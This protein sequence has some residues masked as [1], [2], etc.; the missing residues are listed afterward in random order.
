MQHL[1]VTGSE[2]FIGRE[3]VRAAAA[4]GARITTLDAVP[5]M[6]AGHVRADIRDR[7]LA[8]RIP[9]DVDCVVHLAAISRDGD[10]KADP[11]L[12]L[13]VNVIGTQNVIDAAV[14]RGVRQ[15]IFASSEWV[16]GEVERAGTQTERD[17]IDV[18]RV[19][20]EYALSKLVGERLVANAAARSG[21]AGTVLRFGIV[22]GPR[23]SNWSAVESLFAKTITEDTVTV[24]CGATARRFIHVSDIA[25]GILAAV[26]RTGFETFNLSGDSLVSLRDVVETAGRINERRLVLVESSPAAPSIRNPDNALA[27]ASL[28]WRPAYDLERGLRTLAGALGA[29]QPAA[30]AR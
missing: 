30:P 15:F 7:D 24:G 27:K 20:G 23:A 16:Y 5:A 17:A 28:D 18:S 4:S 6:R 11:R 25:A 1:F 26:G 10:C 21:M 3:L 8:S 2:S 22:Y 29:A 13:D 14:A 19:G 12:A 9:A